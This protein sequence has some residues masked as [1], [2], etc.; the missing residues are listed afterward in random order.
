MSEALTP[1]VEDYLGLIY[2]LQRNGE[3]AIG[4]RLAERLA[5]SRPTVTATLQRMERAGLVALN[6]HKEISLTATGLQAAQDLLRRHMLTERLLHDVLGR[7]WHQ[8]HEEADRLEHHFSPAA[9][10][11]MADLFSQPASCPHGN[12]LPG[13]DPGPSVPLDQVGEGSTAVIVRIVEE[14]EEQSDLLAFL[15]ENGLVP[16]ARLRILSCRPYNE[17]ITV[18]VLPA[19]EGAAPAGPVVLGLSTARLI[20]VR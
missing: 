12:P 5:V 1:T 4:A 10:A 7:P 19:T 6:E 3:S 18:E 14:A 11:Q 2:L 9:V 8:V 13:T 16:S 20:R 15:E 17:T